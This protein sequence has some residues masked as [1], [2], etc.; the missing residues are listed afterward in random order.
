[1]DFNH[2]RP[3]QIYISISHCIARWNMYIYFFI[4]FYFESQIR[5]ARVKTISKYTCRSCASYNGLF[6]R[7]PFQNRLSWTQNQNFS[8]F[9]KRLVTW[10]AKVKTLRCLTTKKQYFGTNSD[11]IKSLFMA[12]HVNHRETET[13]IIVSIV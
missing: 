5:I 7:L 8:N 11:I 4:L 13:I 6:F 9:R 3:I 1:M 10:K 2:S 12:C